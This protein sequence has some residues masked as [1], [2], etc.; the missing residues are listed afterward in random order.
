MYGIQEKIEQVYNIFFIIFK[1]LIAAY[2]IA[3]IGLNYKGTYNRK[4]M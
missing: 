3:H 4:I 2:H 1:K